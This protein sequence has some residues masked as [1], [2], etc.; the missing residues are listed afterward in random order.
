MLLS[1]N[2]GGASNQHR[3]AANGWRKISRGRWRS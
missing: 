1:A 2:A 3:H